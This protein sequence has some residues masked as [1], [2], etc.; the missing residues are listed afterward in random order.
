MGNNMLVYKIRRKSDGK[1]Y[2]GKWGVWRDKGGKL[3]GEKR[4][5]KSAIIM[6]CGWRE[7]HNKRHNFEIIEC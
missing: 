2:G 7:W 6:M 3:Y 5:A 1:W 4:Y